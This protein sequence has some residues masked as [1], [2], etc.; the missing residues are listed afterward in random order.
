M[1]VILFLCDRFSD[2]L[3]FLKK[4]YP[5]IVHANCVGVTH[6][7]CTFSRWYNFG[8]ICLVTQFLKRHLF[9]FLSTTHTLSSVLTCYLRNMHAISQFFFQII[10]MA[11]DLIENID[12]VWTLSWPTT[13]FMLKYRNYRK[14]IPSYFIRKLQSL[15]KNE[16][17]LDIY[18]TDIDQADTTLSV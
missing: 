18:V 6:G 7:F 4:C 10:K 14:V 16:W 3:I 1:P 9:I 13:M 15:T 11:C 2:Y 12:W 17:G 8:F 5:K